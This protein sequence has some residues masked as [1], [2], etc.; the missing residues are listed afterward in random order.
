MEGEKSKFIISDELS[1]K[2]IKWDGRNGTA[3]VL[4]N[5]FTA[6]T[7]KYDQAVYNSGRI[8]PTG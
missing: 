4:R 3:S 8:S 2:L 1:I 7:E 5:I 6:N